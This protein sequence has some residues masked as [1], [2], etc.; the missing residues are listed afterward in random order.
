M[1]QVLWRGLLGGVLLLATLAACAESTAP[2]PP[3]TVYPRL[4]A[5]GPPCRRVEWV[6]W[7][8][9]LTTCLEVVLDD[10]MPPQAAPSLMGL[11]LGPDGTLYL[12]RTAQGAIWAMRVQASGMNRAWNLV[13]S[14]W[15]LRVLIA[16]RK[17]VL[18]GS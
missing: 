12:A 18:V 16:A 7:H 14:R 6:P 2:A 3:R 11:A 13:R 4:Q 10:V 17:S 9:P 15:S 1:R 5:D 8:N